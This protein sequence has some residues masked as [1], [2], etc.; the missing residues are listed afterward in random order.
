M[1][2]KKIFKN[3]EPYLYL[4]PSAIIIILFTYYPFVKNIIQSFFIVDNMG[5]VKRFAALENYMSVLQNEKFLLAIKN[6][7]LFVIVTVPISI[8]AGL[9]L[10]LLARK[11]RKASPVYEALY[12]LPMAM[13]LSVIAIIFQLMLNPTLGIV[14]KV[15]GTSNN[16]LK[17]GAT[18]LPS[19]MFI[20]IWLNIG[21]NFL[22]ML[23]AIRGISEEVIESSEIDGA[24][25]FTRLA[26]ITL[27]LISPTILFLLCSSIAK[28]MITSGLTLVLTGGGPKGSTETIVSFIYKYAIE[29]RNYNIGYAAS[30]VGFGITFVLILISF[31]YEKKGVHY[32]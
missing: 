31:I 17:E 3:V 6:T 24:R 20:E 12:S 13:S 14:N 4:I 8:V 29:N 9:A 18:A 7:L 30:V 2:T 15:L 22:F 23:S 5:V 26:K 21:F 25:G 16:W 10:A 19:L 28:T 32:D 27:P 1:R 11:R